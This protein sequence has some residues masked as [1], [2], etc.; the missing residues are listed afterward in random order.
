MKVGFIGL[1][2]MGMGMA[3]NILKAGHEVTGFDISDVARQ[4]LDEIGGTGVA[5]A[6]DA[7]KNADLLVVMVVNASQ[8]R[9]V[10]FERGAA[11]ALPTGSIVLMCPTIEPEDARDIGHQL[12]EKGLRVLDSPVSGGKTGADSGGLS[13][14]LSGTTETLEEARPVLDAIS[15]KIYHVG[16]EVGLGSTYKVVHQLAAGAHLAIM[17]ELMTFGVRAGCKAETLYEIVSN[18]AGSS[19]MFNDRVPYLLKND[20]APRSA[21]DIFVKDMSLVLKTGENVRMPLPMAAAAQQLF[22]AAS[23]SG[24]GRLNDAAVVKVYEDLTGA[25]VAENKSGRED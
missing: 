15:N 7:A 10:L 12:E 5:D 6:Q 25:N 16:E 3:Q 1:G 20:Y 17:G 9:N 24:Y 8:A 14:M 18:S 21:I 22:L 23:G 2:A 19:W 11:D 13:L 4:A